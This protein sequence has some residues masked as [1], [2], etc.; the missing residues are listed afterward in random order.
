M[1]QQEGQDVPAGEGL[2]P[3]GGGRV[4]LRTVLVLTDGISGHS[5]ECWAHRASP[6]LGT[7]SWVPT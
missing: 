1:P 3:A 6:V 4:E 2:M 7:R 5:H